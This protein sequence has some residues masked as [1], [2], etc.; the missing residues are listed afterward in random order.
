MRL[1]IDTDAF[2]KLAPGG[3]LSAAPDLFGVV[4][5]DCA[6]LPA[7]PQMLRRGTLR[8][9]LGEPLCERLI[10]Q[11][12]RLDRAPDPPAYWLD[13]LRKSPG[14]DPGEAHLL[15]LVAEHGDV[16]ITGDKRALRAASAIPELVARVA[17]KIAVLEA[18][19]IALC[20]RLGD[21]AVRAAVAEV[22]P[23]DAMLAVCFSPGEREPREAVRAYLC[24]TRAAL[25][26]LELWEPP[27]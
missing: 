8:R 16:L 14:I 10:P 5:A 20:H 25:S 7:L 24:E 21:E 15:G 4:L 3:L 11:G 22:V 18:V 27:V 12:E 2:C 13:L 1:L 6:R 19:V 26:P 17:R 23:H 9:R